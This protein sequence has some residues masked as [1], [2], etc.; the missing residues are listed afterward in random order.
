MVECVICKKL[1]DEATVQIFGTP[2]GDEYFVCG[3]DA[4]EK[5]AVERYV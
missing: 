1:L 4:C 2:Y 3:S 5:E